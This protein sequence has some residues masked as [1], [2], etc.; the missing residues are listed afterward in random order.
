[1]SLRVVD[2]MTTL[3]LMRLFRDYVD[4]CIA[5]LA[6][7]GH[8]IRPLSFDEWYVREYQQS[9]QTVLVQLDL[10]WKGGEESVLCR[11]PANIMTG[12]GPPAEANANTCTIGY[13]GSGSF[14]G[15]CESLSEARGSH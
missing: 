9:E 5:E 7:S 4:E 8:T 10:K 1:M 11:I 14:Q 12:S 6:T 2:L 13:C 15:I 3:E